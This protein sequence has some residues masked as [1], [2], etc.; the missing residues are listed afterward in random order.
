[1]GTP[2]KIASKTR[3]LAS[4]VLL[5]LIL[6]AAPRPL[7]AQPSAS[8]RTVAESLFIEARKLMNEQK[9]AEACAKFEASQKLDPAGGTLLNL[10]VCHEKEGKIATAWGEFR[11]SLSLAKREQREDREKLASERIAALEP[12][13]PRLRID[14]PPE[15]RVPGLIVRVNKTP[16]VEAVWGTAIPADPGDGL[17]E[18]EAPGYLPWSTRIKL[19]EKQSEST[20]IPRLNAAPPAASSGARQAPPRPDSLR[21]TT[22]YV[23]LGV[24]ALGLGLGTYFGLQTISRKGQSDDN[25]PQGRCTQRGVDLMED[26]RSSARLSNLGLGLGL[27]AAGAGA[28]LL[29]SAPSAPEAPSPAVSLSILPLPR[30]GAA[31]LGG[32]F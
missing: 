25:C 16:L 26:A 19:A 23:L 14:V 8:D 32:S 17:I 31:S 10:A 20:T 4:L 30:G 1:M 3:P 21:T 18:A 2:S 13:L 22:S 11:Q 15:A 7:H 6:G 27:V 9:Y 28:Y 12:R 5:S 24:G 29:F